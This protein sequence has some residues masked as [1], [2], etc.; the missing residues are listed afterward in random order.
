MSSSDETQVPSADPGLPQIEMSNEQIVIQFACGPLLADYLQRN[1]AWHNVTQHYDEYF[2][3]PNSPLL[4]QGW[5][6]RRRDHKQLSM[7]VTTAQSSTSVVQAQARFEEVTDETKILALIRAHLPKPARRKRGGKSQPLSPLDLATPVPCAHYPFIRHTFGTNFGTIYV[8][9]MSLSPKCD[10][11]Y[12]VGAT[13]VQH[14]SE[15]APTLS[16]LRAMGLH[17]GIDVA[18]RSDSHPKKL[19]AVQAQCEVK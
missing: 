1:A 3:G 19:T 13:T 6:L 11:F 15:I 5:W 9:E 4:R 8:D 17:S 2:D 10:D 7:K 18:G 16:F 12:V 14:S